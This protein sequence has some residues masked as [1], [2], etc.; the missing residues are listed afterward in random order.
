MRLGK[1]KNTLTI[2]QLWSPSRMYRI[3]SNHGGL[4][5]SKH[6]YGIRYTNEILIQFFCQVYKNISS[7]FAIQSMND[8]F[9]FEAERPKKLYT[10]LNSFDFQMKLSKNEKFTFREK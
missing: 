3:N 10:R 7:R 2:L 9:F 1:R 8:M 6:E 4:H 5:Y